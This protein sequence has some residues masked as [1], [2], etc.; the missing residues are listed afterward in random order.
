[1]GPQKYKNENKKML[2]F[3][4]KYFCIFFLYVPRFGLGE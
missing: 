3:R 4:G 1:M 2:D